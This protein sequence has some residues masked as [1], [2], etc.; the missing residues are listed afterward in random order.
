MD[1]IIDRLKKTGLVRPISDPKQI[2]IAKCG[3]G[4]GRCGPNPFLNR[5]RQSRVSERRAG[6]L[7]KNDQEQVPVIEEAESSVAAVPIKQN[8]I[9]PDVVLGGV[10]V[11]GVILMATL[12]QG[13]DP[14]SG[15]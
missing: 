10:I 15:D 13:S 8:Q 1:G 9:E 2:E 12:N 14:M 3:F 4:T 7:L 11:F 6:L 5:E